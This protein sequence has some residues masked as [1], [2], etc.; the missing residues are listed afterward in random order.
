VDFGFEE[1][2]YVGEEEE[3]CVGLQSRGENAIEGQYM[4]YFGI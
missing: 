3:G 4:H 2:W 1:M